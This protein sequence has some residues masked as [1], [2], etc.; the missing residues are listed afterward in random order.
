MSAPG[1]VALAAEQPVGDDLGHRVAGGDQAV[2]SGPRMQAHSPIAQTLGSAVR[3]ASS[4]TTPP[5]SPTSQPGVAG[6]LV[7]GPDAGGEDDEVDVERGR[8][9]RTP[10]GD[11]R[12]LPAGPIFEV[13][14]PVCTVTPRSSIVPAQ[15][16]AAALV[17]LQ[18]HQPRARTRRRVVAR[19]SGRSALAASSP[20]RPPPTTA[21]ADRAV[22]V[23]ARLST[24]AAQVG[25]VVDRAVDEAPRQVAARDRRH[26]RRT[27]RWRAP[28]RRRAASSRRTS[29]P[30][31]PRGRWP[32]RPRRGA[33]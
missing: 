2:G 3:Q 1:K 14:V 20:S 31:G 33:G 17:D 16:L 24:Y 26:E 25:E 30:C 5:R 15:H 29:S 28:A 7:A 32:W 8:R 13:A 12:P 18:R 11:T 4:T 23:A 19:P 21:P 22:L 10:S 9:R 27:S 6:Q